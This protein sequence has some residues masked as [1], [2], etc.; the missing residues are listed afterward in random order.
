MGTFSVAQT[1]LSFHP[2]DQRSSP[3]SLISRSFSA[4][5][6]SFQSHINFTL[7][8]RYYTQAPNP[9]RKLGIGEGREI[10][11][12]RWSVPA[13]PL[14]IHSQIFFGGV[15]RMEDGGVRASQPKH[16]L[17]YTLVSPCKPQSPRVHHQMR[18]RPMGDTSHSLT[19]AG[20]GVGTLP[21]LAWIAHTSSP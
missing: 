5:F 18:S 9:E 3:L 1:V 4:R 20:T 15:H 6:F 13:V 21:S 8:A 10:H 7:Y 12:S 16:W 11:T 19:L 2:S 14:P 17:S